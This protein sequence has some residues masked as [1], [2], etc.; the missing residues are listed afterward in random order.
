MGSIIR[1]KLGEDV[2]DVALD[3]FFSDGEVC[4][5]HLVRIPARDQPE[6]VK[7]PRGQGIVRRMLGQFRRDLRRDSFVTRMNQTDG[8]GPFFSQR[9]LEQV[10]TS[11]GLER[12]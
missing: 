7:F 6:D 11:A 1:R 4:G 9:T 10:A 3:G 12:P 2:L 8:L 5:D